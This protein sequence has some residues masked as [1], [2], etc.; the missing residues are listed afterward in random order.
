MHAYTLN[1]PPKL[2]QAIPVSSSARRACWDRI[3]PWP[4]PHGA[5]RTDPHAGSGDAATLT[6][7]YGVVCCTA[8]QLRS[9]TKNT[10]NLDPLPVNTVHLV[11]T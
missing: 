5:L 8:V 11:T 1:K 2:S 6:V 4:A 10:V 9:A 3:G 7:Q